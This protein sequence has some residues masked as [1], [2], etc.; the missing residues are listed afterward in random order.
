MTIRQAR[1]SHKRNLP[2]PLLSLVLSV[3]DTAP[4]TTVCEGDNKSSYRRLIMNNEWEPLN[5]D[6]LCIFTKKH[7]KI[8]PLE[9][10]SDRPD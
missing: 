1:I 2:K 8:Y 7:L 6:D 5:P 4:I 10:R 9:L 3:L